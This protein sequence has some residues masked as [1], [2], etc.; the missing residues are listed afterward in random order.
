MVLVWRRDIPLMIEKLFVKGDG[1][2]LIGN[3]DH[4]D[5]TSTDTG[6]MPLGAIFNT[7]IL[8]NSQKRRCNIIIF[9]IR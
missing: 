6:D 2:A 8:I 5:G 3:P 1:Y 4:S 7:L 9:L